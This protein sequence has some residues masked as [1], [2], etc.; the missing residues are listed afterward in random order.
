[1]TNTFE[2]S[3]LSSIKIKFLTDKGQAQKKTFFLLQ[4]KKNTRELIWPV[5][6]KVFRLGFLS[7]FIIQTW[8]VLC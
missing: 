5:S 6:T 2:R 1:M 3:F 4:L 7:N 8:V